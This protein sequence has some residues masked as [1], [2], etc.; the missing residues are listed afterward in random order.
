MN[1][2]YT[3]ER[4]VQILIQVLKANNIKKVIASPGTTNI[5]FIASIQQDPFFT[6]YSAPDERSAGYIACGMAAETGEPVV[7]S[8]T[9]ATASRNYMPALT[10][11]YY[12]KLPILAITSSRRSS[13]IGHNYDQVTDRTQLPNDI[14]KL[15]VQLPVILDADNEWAVN[16]AANKAILE[17]NHRGKGPVHI[18]LETDYSRIYDIKDLPATRIIRRYTNR[19]ELPAIEASRVVIFVGSHAPWSERLSESV[20][21]FCVQNN[22]IVLCDQI[23]NYKG[24]YRAFVNF[25]TIQRDF[26]SIVMNADLMIHIGDVAASSYTINAKSVWRVNEDGEIRDPFRKLTNV[27]EMTEE[28]FFSSYINEDSIDSNLEFWNE[29]EKEEK[30]IRALLDDKVERLPFSN[31]WIASQ[32]ARVLPDNSVLHL[33]IQNSLRFWNFFD[34]PHS[35]LGFCNTGGFGIDGPLSTVIGAALASPTKIH[36]VVLGDLAFFYDLNSL[37]NRHLPNNMRI[38]LINNGR[39][40]EFKLTGNPG[41]MFGDDADAYIAAA[42]HYGKKSKDLVKHYAQDLGMT[43][44][45][46]EN[47]EEYLAIKGELLVSECSAPIILEV[48]TNSEDENEALTLISTTVTTPMKTMVRTVKD[49]TRTTIGERGTKV[50]TTIMGKQ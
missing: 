32:T 36:Y 49:F 18:N 8:C 14:A 35:V 12:R 11:A 13:R 16:V 7:I 4:N 26:K 31:A 39:G 41:A 3:T 24:K 38:I 10:E 44:Y 29:Y 21:K 45:F 30:S 33:G 15:S 19:D 46:A 40:T 23:S 22:A 25:H 50:L 5:C 20:D 47:K 2:Y 6:I 37:G 48:F 42:G 28:E 27:F 43:Y 17:L 1:S 9:G 34:T